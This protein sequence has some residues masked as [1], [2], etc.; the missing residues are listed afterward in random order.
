MASKTITYVAKNIEDLGDAPM[1]GVMVVRERRMNHFEV[2]S[3]LVDTGCLGVKVVMGTVIHDADDLEELKEDLFTDGYVEKSAAWG[4]KFVESA[5]VYARKLGFGPPRDYKKAARVFGGTDAKD[6]DERFEF[7]RKGK[8]FYFQGPNESPQQANK[9]IKILERRCGVDGF[10]FI[11]GGLSDDA[12]VEDEVDFCLELMEDGDM[13]G[14]GSRLQR[15]LDENPEDKDALFAMGIW[16][17]YEQQPDQALLF[18]E[19]ATDIDPEFIEAWINR[20]MAHM[21]LSNVSGNTEELP[22]GGNMWHMAAMLKCFQQVM[23]CEQEDLS[24]QGESEVERCRSILEIS[25]KEA[26]RSGISLEVYIESM[27]NYAS[28]LDHMEELEW[29]A[30]LEQFRVTLELNPLSYHACGNSGTCLIA[31]DRVNE[32]REM[33]QRALKM[34]PNYKP[35][36]DNLKLLEGYDDENLPPVLGH[37]MVD[38]SKPD[39]LS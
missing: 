6:C 15:L 1:V 32:A 17:L 9:I 19:A 13:K 16:Y 12:S 27:E 18:F 37:K 10:H 14:A 22:G 38:S 21:H 23:E 2:G 26:E 39:G 31:L 20:G 35:A 36:L 4:R 3:F 25:A 28:G 11:V 34:E 30:A 7:G 8:P 33:L 29:E 5:I 24:E